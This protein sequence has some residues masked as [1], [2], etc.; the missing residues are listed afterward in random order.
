MV[1]AGP[2]GNK[3]LIAA[4]PCHPTTEDGKMK[5]AIFTVC[6]ALIAGCTSTEE[7]AQHN[8]AQIE[9]V[10]V[11]REALKAEKQA[12][13]NAQVA[14][15][16]ALAEVAK[17]N[18]DQAGAVTVALAVQGLGGQNEE[19]N[20]PLVALQQQPNEALQ[21]T[22]A[23]APIAGG[24]LTTLGTAVVSGNVQKRQIEATRDVQIN[25][26]NSHASVVASV[27]GL[28]QAA[29]AN[30]GDSIGGDYYSLTDSSI[31]NSQTSTTTQ[32]TT[33]TTTSIADSY[34]TDNSITDS[35][36]TD[37]TNN[38]VTDSYNTTDNTDNS[39]V[40]N[41]VINYDYSTV[42]YEGQELTLGGLL[43]YLQSTG[44]AYELTIGDTVYT[45]DGSGEPVEIDCTQ[46]QFS[47]APPQCVGG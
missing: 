16:N 33:S 42:T 24:V 12:E 15:Y 17:A 47:P 4:R 38:S 45:V 27:A 5:L 2:S 26:A 25:A 32:T 46:P 10:R 9:I 37:N 44:L 14:L 19:S 28:G 30:V 11:Q 18:P 8:Q 22:Q 34:N 41:S 39:V 29:V 23:L 40:D 21:W 1:G 35:Y 13:A 31:D 43:E 20:T 36:N 6:L 7:K 3:P